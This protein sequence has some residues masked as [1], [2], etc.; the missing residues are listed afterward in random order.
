VG[1]PGR[2][3][4]HLSKQTLK[5]GKIHTVI[6]DEADRMLDMGFFEDI[7][8]ILS[9]VPQS[10]QTLLF[11]ATF[12]PEI[13]SLSQE[14]MK[15]PLQIKVVSE[16]SAEV[17]EEVF[18]AVDREVQKEA[19][20]K[21]LQFYQPE[22]AI[23]FAN[24]KAEVM[25]LTDFLRET[26]FSALDLHG[27][28]EQYERTETLLQFANRSIRI[29]VATDVAAR[30]L[31]IERVEMV[32]NYGLP[33]KKEDYIQDYFLRL[34]EKFDLAYLIPDDPGDRSCGDRVGRG[35]VSCRRSHRGCS[36]RRACPGTPG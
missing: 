7:E 26:G 18:Y 27:D 20:V 25:D 22:S 21:V 17:I 8:K 9:R 11:S 33:R 13:K 36:C 16:H 1:T 28:L 32:V 34:M 14:F 15:D 10:R 31:D 30:G 5:L 3:L 6:L 2:I 35:H 12:P 23:L 29:L 4:D 19:L 24:T